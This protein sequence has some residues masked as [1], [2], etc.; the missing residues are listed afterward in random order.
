MTKT[1]RL[2][3]AGRRRA[4]LIAAGRLR[5]GRRRGLSILRALPPDQDGPTLTELL[6]RE[7][8]LRR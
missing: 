7:R 4:E 1:R 2:S 8:S 6:L 5:P 3:P